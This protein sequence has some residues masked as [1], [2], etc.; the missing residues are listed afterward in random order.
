MLTTFGS[1]VMAPA[2]C[3]IA[4]FERDISQERKEKMKI[5]F[6]F[7][8]SLSFLYKNCDRQIYTIFLSSFTEDSYRK[9]SQIHFLICLSGVVEFYYTGRGS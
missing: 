5:Q 7:R 4:Y 8:R 6:D 3:K 9:K 1:G 2:G